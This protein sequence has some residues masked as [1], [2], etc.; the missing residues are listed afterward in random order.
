MDEVVVGDLP[1]MADFRASW[2]EMQGWVAQERVSG[3][4]RGV[5]QPAW[6]MDRGVTRWLSGWRL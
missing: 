1:E 4:L 2:A 5:A 6:T 3:V